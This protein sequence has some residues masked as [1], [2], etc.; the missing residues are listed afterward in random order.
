[1]EDAIQNDDDRLLDL[2]DR[3]LQQYGEGIRSNIDRGRQLSRDINGLQTMAETSAQNI[4]GA[5]PMF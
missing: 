2:A 1:M 5:G 4:L 3:Q